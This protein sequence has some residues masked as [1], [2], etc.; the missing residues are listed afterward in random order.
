MT[1]KRK[2]QR[3][4][5]RTVPGEQHV[6]QTKSERSQTVVMAKVMQEGGKFLCFY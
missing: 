1:D 6:E 5:I 3:L 4:N 2:I